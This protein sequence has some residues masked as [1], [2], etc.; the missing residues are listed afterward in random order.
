MTRADALKALDD[1][2]ADGVK[3]LY[4]VLRANVIS[5]TPDS[6]GKFEKGIA[7]HIETHVIASA[8]VTKIFEE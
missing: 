4:S 3:Q 2:F 7:S 8:S 6:A 5:G 1:A